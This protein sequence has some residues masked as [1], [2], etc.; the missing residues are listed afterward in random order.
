MR[1]PL[2]L[3]IGLAV[4]TTPAVASIFI[5][6]GSF[7]GL[8]EDPPNASA[9]TGFTTVT[10]DT[11]AMTMRTQADF[12]GLGTNTTAAHIHVRANSGVLSGP[13]ATQLPSFT[14]FP[15]GVTSGTFDNT[16]DMSLAASW[17]PTYITNNGGTTASAFAAL[18]TSMDAGLTYFNIHTSGFAGGEIRANLAPVPEPATLIALGIGAAALLRRRAKK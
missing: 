13:V 12:S 11:T 6:T 2:A 10:I 5:Y 16:F 3:I 18:L 4:A 14:G 8:N 17:N 9:G 7:S 15:L 1:R